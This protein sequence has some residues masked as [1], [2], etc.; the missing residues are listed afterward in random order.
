M[1]ASLRSGR[2]WNG[3]CV[4]TVDVELFALTQGVHFPLEIGSQPPHPPV[5]A[6]GAI[7]TPGTDPGLAE[8]LML[9]QRLQSLL[10][11]IRQEVLLVAEPPGSWN[12]TSEDHIAYNI[13]SLPGS[14]RIG[15]RLPKFW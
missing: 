2:Q 14:P 3:V 10:R 13:P 5:T 8:G 4:Y 7:V 15:G 1:A 12:L 6:V 11:V 9:T